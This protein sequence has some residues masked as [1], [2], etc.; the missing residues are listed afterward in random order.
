MRKI[1]VLLLILLGI[2]IVIQFFNPEKNPGILET[3]QDFLK[4]S[5]VPDTLAA[6]LLNACYDCHSDHTRYPWYSK[7]SP[8]S[9][10]LNHHIEEGKSHLNFSSWGMLDKAQK[11]GVL[12][13]ICEE[14]TNG[15]MPLKSYLLIHRDARLGPDQIKSICEWTEMEAMRILS[16]EKESEENN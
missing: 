4:G 10:Y 14:C 12:D 15:S 6:V 16:S 9:W 7:V 5:M 11:I 1:Y 13:E 8:L 3:N 2:F